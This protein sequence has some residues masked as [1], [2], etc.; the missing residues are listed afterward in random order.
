[1]RISLRRCAPSFVYVCAVALTV[2]ACK[3][4]GTDEDRTQLPYSTVDREAFNFRAAELYVPLFWREDSNRNGALEPGE[5]AVLSAVSRDQPSEW[6]DTS[7]RY[8]AKFANAYERIRKSDS[9]PQDASKDASELKRLDLVRQEL[10]QGRPTLVESDLTQLTEGEKNFLN[11]M[12]QAAELIERLYAKQKGVFGMEAQIAESDTASRAMFRRN[13]S[14]FCVQPKTEN[15]PACT[16]LAPKPPRVVGLYP[17]EIQSDLKFCGMLEKQRNATALMDHFSVVVNGEAANEFKA[18]PYHEAYG[19]EMFAI[20]SELE[21]SAT[22]LGD[23]EAALKNYL[24][25]AAKSFRSNDWELANEAWVAMNAQNSKWFLRI[26][27]DEVYYDPC[28]WK[29]GFAFQLARIN[30]DSIE[31][32]RKLDPLKNEME[33]TLAKMAGTPYKARDV[34]F[35]IPD[36]ID[37]VLNAGDKRP[38]SGATV[39]QSLPNWGPVAEKGGRTVAM[40]NFY[41]DADSQAAQAKTMASVFC[42]KTN[43]LATTNPRESIIGSLLHEAA[44]N[45]GPSHEYKVNGKVDDQIFGG[46]MASTLEEF[47][48]QMSSLYLTDWLATKGIFTPEEVRK[49]HVRDIAWA[50]GHISRGMYAA[51]GTPRNYSQ[52]AAMQVGAFLK[53]GGLEWHAEATA[54]NGADAGC[55]EVN[56]E[57]LSPAI[58]ALET[59]VLKIKASGD[60][61]TAETLKAQYVD[62]TDDYAQ[63]K[64]TITERWLRSPRASFVYSVRR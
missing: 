54:A 14:P 61:K 43:A 27:P 12:L 20:A 9:T 32:Q 53:D 3:K 48:A 2:S 38:P 59:T 39:G 5:L 40:T 21:A 7:G 13:Q 37:V 62:A 22:G 18:V 63:I 34:Q 25:A 10:A 1:M 30:P 46:P 44:H 52:L 42:A 17:A 56:F 49:I 11:H 64:Q 8:T 50:F 28:A 45:L 57:K 33:S 51:D 19:Q 47:K 41:T 24:A 26:A 6:V 35:A 15:D 36:F 16:A 55:I 60:K 58:E 31:W 4:P 29:A 23:D